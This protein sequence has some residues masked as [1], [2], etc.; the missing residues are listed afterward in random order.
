MELLLIVLTLI[1]ALTIF[2]ALGLFL[3]KG[4][5]R[6]V[7]NE[8]TNSSIKFSTHTLSFR[9]VLAILLVGGALIPLAFIQ[10]LVNER[11]SLFDQVATRMA[12]EWGGAQQISGPVLTIPY[13]YK[14]TVTEKSVVEGEVKYIDRRVT[15]QRDLHILPEQ[16]NITSILDTHELRRGL[17]SAP[18]YDGTHKLSGEFNWP[19]LSKLDHTPEK[20]YFDQA[21][22]TLLVHDTKGIGAN[23][24]LKWN[25]KE[26]HLSAGAGFDT[27][28]QSGIHARL[29]LNSSLLRTNRAEF[30]MSLELRGSHAIHFAP[31]GRDSTIELSADW[32]DPSFSGQVLPQEREISETDFSA[33]WNVGHL[34]RSFSQ[35]TSLQRSAKQSYFEQIH[36]FSFGTD[37]FQTVDLYTLLTRTVKYGALFIILTFV[38]VF[39]IEFASGTR[40]HWLQHMVIGSALSLFYLVVLAFSEHIGFATAYLV[41]TLIIS[42]LVGIYTAAFMR[43]K[44]LAIAIFGVILT[45]YGV[46]YAILQLEDFALLIGTLLLLGFLAIG[47]YLTSGL[48]KS[49]AEH[50][51]PS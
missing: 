14:E 45:L 29:K 34:S 9:M 17:Y 35:I 5:I 32:A 28:A 1:C 26:V 47:M 10:G 19:D 12:S 44:R 43:K 33:K 36:Q 31:T 42:I 41:G 48:N 15:R 3:L 18:I 22:L 39:A 49:K 25:D 20:I 24:K 2:G 46:L 21:I 23:A 7:K 27:I 16:L 51:E 4:L 8:T 11:S 30:E 13:E 50:S 40:F 6:M 38:S 37:L